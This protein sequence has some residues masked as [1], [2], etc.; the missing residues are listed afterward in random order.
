MTEHTHI[1][2]IYNSIEVSG[3]QHAAAAA[4]AKSLQSVRLYVT[5]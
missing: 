5:P 1:S 3:I 4:A 2:L